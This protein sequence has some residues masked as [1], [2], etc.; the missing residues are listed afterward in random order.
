MRKMFA[1]ML[2]FALIVGVTTITHPAALAQPT[3]K[4]KDTV[5]KGGTK[6]GVGT[7]EVNEGKDGKFRFFVRN[8]DGKLI[9]M[10]GP[11]GFATDKEAAKAVD[12]LREV[13]NAAKVSTGKA[14]AKS[15]KGGKTD[16]AGKKDKAAKKDE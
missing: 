6:A 16:K 1:C 10:S 2:M 4:D 13:I 14:P 8:A 11:G 5:K 15:D 7:I 9:A 12:E 3:K